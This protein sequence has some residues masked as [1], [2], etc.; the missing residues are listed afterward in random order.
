M[1]AVYRR[2]T[3]LA[4]LRARS[5]WSLQGTAHRPSVVSIDAETRIIGFLSLLCSCDGP[6]GG[7]TPPTFRIFAPLAPRRPGAPAHSLPRAVKTVTG[8]RI[9]HD[10]RVARKL[11]K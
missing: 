3:A 5:C 11:P 4:G 9:R 1:P 2:S 7:S 10:H 8:P 6:E